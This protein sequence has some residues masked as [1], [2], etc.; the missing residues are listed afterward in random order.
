MAS[1][2]ADADGEKLVSETRTITLSTFQEEVSHAK[3][4]LKVLP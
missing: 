3:V 4:V 1:S 2:T